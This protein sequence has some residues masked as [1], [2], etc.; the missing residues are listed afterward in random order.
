LSL[1][2]RFTRMLPETKGVYFARRGAFYLRHP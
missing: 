1:T 2:S